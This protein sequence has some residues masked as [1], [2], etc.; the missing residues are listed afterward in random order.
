MKVPEI[1]LKKAQTV[2]KLLGGKIS[3]LGKL[4]GFTYYIHQLKEPAVVG[5]PV[6]YRYD[7]H[8]AL[9]ISDG[10]ALDIINE[11]GVE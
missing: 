2:L 11:L 3:Y 8:E 1:V 5:Y 7:G 9:E 10:W 4:D 6:V